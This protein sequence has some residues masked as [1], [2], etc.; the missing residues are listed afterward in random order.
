MDS[1]LD[2]ATMLASQP[3]RAGCL[4]F[5]TCMAVAPH[6]P[7]VQTRVMRG[8]QDLRRRFKSALRRAV[9]QETIPED[10]HLEHTALFLTSQIGGMTVLARGGASAKELRGAAK[11]ALRQLA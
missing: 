10:T 11:T 8:I 5:N 9:E 3:E 2:T 6:D 7:E 4:M 1:S